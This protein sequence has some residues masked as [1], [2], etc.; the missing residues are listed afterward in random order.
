MKK[1]FLLCATVALSLLMAGSITAEAK[2][3]SKSNCPGGSYQ[4]CFD[5][6]TKKGLPGSSAAK[7]CR[8][9]CEV[10]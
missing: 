8:A 5:K 10:Y 9:K 3:S 1:A 6:L 2:K 4:A 7:S